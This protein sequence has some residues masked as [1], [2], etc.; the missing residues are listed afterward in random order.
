MKY[1][2]KSITP[3]THTDDAL[4]NKIPI[5][6][7]T[8]R[9]AQHR[10]SVSRSGAKE[11][12]RLPY[13]PTLVMTSLVIFLVYFT[14]IREENDI[15]VELQRSLYSRIQGLEEFQLNLS[16]H[17]NKEHNKSTHDIECR[18]R[19]IAQEKEANRPKM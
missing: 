12:N 8:S 14:L 3:V 6:F 5:K 1:C 15:D 4:D 13:E 10:A 2:T 17:Y 16:L 9:A 11:D 18:L 19:E 7:S